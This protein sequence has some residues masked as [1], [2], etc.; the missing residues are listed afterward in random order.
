MLLFFRGQIAKSVTELTSCN[1]VVVDFEGKPLDG[2]Y[3][4]GCV[5]PFPAQDW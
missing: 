3:L 4:E 5:V 2:A 1:L